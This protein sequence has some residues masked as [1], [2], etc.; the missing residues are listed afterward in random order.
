[1][2]ETRKVG[3][4]MVA[5]KE[6]GHENS[7]HIYDGDNMCLGFVQFMAGYEFHSYGC[8]TAQQLRTIAAFLD[9]LNAKH[10]DAEKEEG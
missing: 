6:Y 2:P 1:M 3:E 9:E 5:V 8:L 10:K 4:Y 7:W